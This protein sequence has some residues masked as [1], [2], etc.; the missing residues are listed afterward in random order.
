MKQVQVVNPEGK[1]IRRYP[2]GNLTTS[3]VAFGG[4]KMN[5]LYVTGALGAYGS[6]SQGALFRLDLGPV[7]GR[8]ILPKGPRSREARDT[9]D[10][11][12]MLS[13]LL[14]GLKPTFMTPGAIRM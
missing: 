2:G 13:R 4:P 8:V 14:K 6:G 7:R 5:Q 12:Y 10:D 3:N 1:V 11:G 9:W